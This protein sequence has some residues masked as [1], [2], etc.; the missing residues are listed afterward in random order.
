ML[1]KKIDRFLR[2]EHFILLSKNIFTLLYMIYYHSIIMNYFSLYRRIIRKKTN[3]FWNKLRI[4]NE[5]VLENFCNRIFYNYPW[6]IFFKKTQQTGSLEQTL[7]ITYEQ[8]RS[9]KET[10]E[11]LNSLDTLAETGNCSG[12]HLNVRKEDTDLTA[13]HRAIKTA[14]SKGLSIN[15]IGS[16]LFMIDL[17]NADLS[18]INLTGAELNGVNL[19]G[20]NLSG[21]NLKGARINFSI[22]VGANLTNAN[23]TGA[24]LVRCNLNGAMVDGATFQNAVI[25]SISPNDV[26]FSKANIIGTTFQH[27][28]HWKM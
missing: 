14:K 12:C 21:A 1:Y 19:T 22:L 15:L 24:K 16:H 27:T 8:K 10:Q 5:Q 18:N 9:E 25:D 3:E 26:D 17:A 28:I 7:L 6:N 20:A 2:E 23:L 4:L 13:A 11:L